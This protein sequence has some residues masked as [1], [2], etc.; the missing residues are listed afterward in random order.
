MWVSVAVV[1]TSAQFLRALSNAGVCDCCSDLCSVF[2]DLIA[3]G[4]LSVF[5]LLLSF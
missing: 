4:C 3:C 5:K 1:Q 2:E